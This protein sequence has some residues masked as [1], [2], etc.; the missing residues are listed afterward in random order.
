MSVKNITLILIMVFN[1]CLFGQNSDRYRNLNW[2]TYHSL[3]LADSIDVYSDDWKNISISE[4][5]KLFQIPGDELSTM[6]TEELIQAYTDC[7]FTRN[8]IFHNEIEGFYKQLDHGFNGIG[9][10]LSRKNAGEGVIAYYLNLDP[11]D[12]TISPAGISTMNQIYFIEYF[13]GI[14]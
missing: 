7:L 12:G 6:S 2:R 3:N 10:L 13:L 9:E 14:L 5:A 1:I 4:R 11:T 8:I